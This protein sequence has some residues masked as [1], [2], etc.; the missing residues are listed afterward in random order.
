MPVLGVR[1]TIVIGPRFVFLNRGSAEYFHIILS[2]LAVAGAALTFE[3]DGF[4][5]D[6][7]D[8]NFNG[9]GRTYVAWQW[10]T[11]GAAGS[12]NTD[13]SINTTTTSVNQ[14]AGFSINTYTGTGSNA[15]VGHGLGAVPKMI[16]IK[17]T[18][19]SESWIV[20][21]EGVGNDGNLYLNLTNAK[22]TQAVFQDTTPPTSSVFSL[23]T[24]DGANKASGVHVAYCFA[25][26]PGYSS[27]G[28]YTGNGSTDG[29]FVN[30]GSKPSWLMIKALVCGTG[31]WDIF[32][33]KRDPFNVMDAVLDADNTT[34]E[35]TYSTIKLD[36]FK[37][38]I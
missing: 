13:G 16:L 5:L 34:A 26:V 35:T 25:E 15:T 12:S 4:D 3:A 17:D 1:D 9:S 38:R 14:T 6:T 2:Y 20:Y 10:K 27:F 21:H 11:Q 33:N 31:N 36:F 28:S 8:V 37:Q 22:A 18:T 30:T 7:T 23:G 32:D 24:T 29:P 19:N